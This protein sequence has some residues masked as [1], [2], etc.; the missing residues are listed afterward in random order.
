MI[1]VNN[2]TGATG[3]LPRGVSVRLAFSG[4]RYADRPD[5][6]PPV[7]TA[8]SMF[9][10][11][12][13]M[14]LGFIGGFRFGG[15]LYRRHPIKIL[16]AIDNDRKC[17]ATYKLNIGDHAEFGDLG[18]L[19]PASLP[20]ADLLL[21]GFPCQDFSW[22]GPRTGLNGK[23]G[24][25]YKALV[26]YMAHHQPKIA[27]GENVPHMVQMNGGAVWEK[28]KG[29]LEGAGYRCKLWKL[30]AADYGV[31]QNR[32]RLI[33]MCVRNDL[34]G[35]PVLPAGDA[36]NRRSIDWAIGDLVKMRGEDLANHDQYFKAGLA[37]NGHG[38]GDEVNVRGQLAYTIR[39]NAKSRIQFHYE[40]PRRLT[41]R[42]CARIQSFPDRFVFP[43][44]ATHNAKEIGNAVPPVLAH[45]VAES[46][47]TYLHDLSYRNKTG[48]TNARSRS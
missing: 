24:G 21:G 34:V 4:V 38:Q 15:K 48:Q 22:C 29:D 11:C 47:V 7:A 32:E 46:V 31:P 12:G 10:G 27:I 5:A 20:A 18:S 35:D 36:A 39:A 16:K 8:L 26:N 37:K 19:A 1:S 42:E 25:L 17:V 6:V 41:M 9:S 45:V 2:E 13:G 43:H 30:H 28:I 44:A 33:L 23:R 14:D 40:L 3:R